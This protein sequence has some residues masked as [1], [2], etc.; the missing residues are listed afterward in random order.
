[1]E[2]TMDSQDGAIRKLL[3]TCR[4]GAALSRGNLTVVPLFGPPCGP[5]VTLLR[6]A[7]R[8]GSAEITEVGEQGSVNLLLVRNRGDRP[9]LLLDG[10]LVVGGK[11]NRVVNATFL[12]G[13]R[14]EARIPVSCVEH[15]RWRH[16]GKRF[17]A[18]AASLNLGLK[19]AKFARLMESLK[20]DGRYDAD[21][22]AVWDDVAS[23]SARR[24]VA[25]RTDALADAV[26]V[27]LP[28]A[29]QLAQGIR[30]AEGQTGLAV[31]INGRFA[32]LDLFGRP[33]VLAAAHD[34]LVRASAL[35]AM[36]QAGGTRAARRV[37]ARA[38]LGRLARS[39][40]A[41]HPAP[42]EGTSVLLEDRRLAGCALV[43]PDGPVH[44]AAFA[45]R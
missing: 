12:V 1:M 42:G 36:D 16:E 38:V 24:G 18:S 37:S 11:Q 39:A 34:A 32:G 8:D 2:P 30:P 21:Q 45:V 27:S 5:E 35:E 6:D 41:G 33:A 26:E 17:E 3:E 19:S 25:S 9:L 40:K 14:S 10:D 20:R 23:Y 43:S 15:G 7:L 13:A 44:L 31:F 29:E 4:P 28:G 22:G